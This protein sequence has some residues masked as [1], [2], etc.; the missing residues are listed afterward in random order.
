MDKVGLI[1]KTV[2]KIFSLKT[3]PKD[4]KNAQININSFIHIGPVIINN[5]DCRKQR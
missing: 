5:C 2:L 3:P 4:E 1:D